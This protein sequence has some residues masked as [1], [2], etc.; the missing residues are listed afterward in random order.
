MPLNGLLEGTC[1]SPLRCL[2]ACL[3]AASCVVLFTG[4]VWTTPSANLGQRTE[5]ETAI[6]ES[7]MAREP[8]RG[9]AVATCP[10]ASSNP[11]DWFAVPTHACCMT[12]S[13]RFLDVARRHSLD[14]VS[15]HRHGSHNYDPLYQRFLGPLRCRNG[16][17]VLEIGLG[18]GMPYGEGHSLSMLLEFLPFAERIVEVDYDAAC[19]ERFLQA[20]LDGP[21]AWVKATSQS[22][23]AAVARARVESGDETSPADL[24]RLGAM[25]GPFDA[26]IDDGGHSMKMQITALST[27][28]PYVRPGGVLIIEDL[29]TAFLEVRL[30]P[31][32]AAGAGSHV[33]PECQCYGVASLPALLFVGGV[34]VCDAS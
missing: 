20:M 4:A 18:C 25:H 2:V 32:A 28:W 9:P 34:C 6:T 3:T 15:G 33:R 29:H 22:W 23:A 30:E 21:P 24:Q 26:V 10:P 7:A 31:G 17:R 16:T 1:G 12:D 27:L 14:K 11:G 19:V 13:P 5:L 8:P